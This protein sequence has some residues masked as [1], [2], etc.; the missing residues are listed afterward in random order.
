M[1]Y[2]SFLT[3]SQPL[4]AE[5]AY[6]C[7]THDMRAIAAGVHPRAHTHA[8]RLKPTHETP[9]T[10]SPDPTARPEIALSRGRVTRDSYA[11]RVAPPKGPTDP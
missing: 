11:A 8:E 4:C 9:V 5:N 3:L 6:V 7:I 2:R 1:S 10:H